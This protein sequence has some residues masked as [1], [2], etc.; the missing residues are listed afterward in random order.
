[1]RRPWWL[2]L[3]F[4]VVASVTAA[5][6]LLIGHSSLRLWALGIMGIVAIVF[7]VLQFRRRTLGRRSRATASGRGRPP[8]H[9]G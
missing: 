9:H 5:S 2:L 1:M 4:G 6:Q 8:W 7:G 3:A